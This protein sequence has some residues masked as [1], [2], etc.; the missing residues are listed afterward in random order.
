MNKS[1]GVSTFTI[2]FLLLFHF[3]LIGEN[4]GKT[5]P[6]DERQDLSGEWQ[7]DS[8]EEDGAIEKQH[9]NLLFYSKDKK[10]NTEAISS[11]DARSRKNIGGTNRYNSLSGVL[12][13]LMLIQ[14]GAIPGDEMTLS[15]VRGINSFGIS[16]RFPLVLYDGIETDNRRI[17]PYS[18]ERVTVLKDAAAT[19]MYGIRGAGGVI[20]IESR[21]G[22][23]GPVTV[24]VNS[25]GSVLQPMRVPSFL[26]S[27]DYARLYNEARMNEGNDPRYSDE[28]IEGY[29][30]GTDP[31]NYPDINWVNNYLQDYTYQTRNNISFSG[32]DE[33]INYFLSGGYVYNTGIFKT[34]EDENPY[35]TNTNFSATNMQARLNY[36]G[37]T[38]LDLHVD[39]KGRFDSRR[40]PGRY[41]DF[42]SRVFGQLYN[43]P[44]LAYPV[45]N[46]DGS[47]GG[48]ADF[49]DN[50]F[51]LL[52]NSGY[53]IWERT[54]ISSIV[55]LSYDLGF[56]AQGLR[57][58]S[59]FGYLSFADHITDRSKEF[60][61]YQYLG[62][63]EYDQFGQNESMNNASRYEENRRNLSGEVGLNYQTNLGDDFFSAGL[64]AEY[65]EQSARVEM[66]PRVYQSI[67][68][69]A[70]YRMND[71]YLLDLVFSYSGSEQFP[72]NNRYGFFP[73]ASLGWIL[74]EESFL[75]N[76]SFVNFLKIRTSYG[77]TGNDFDPY[78]SNKPYFGYLENF[79][80]GNGYHFGYDASWMQG[81]Y[82][83][84]VRNPALIWE[85]VAKFNIG[86]DA[87]FL[88]N[89][90][91]LS[92]DYFN[93]ETKDI[94]IVGT[95]Q[96]IMGSEFWNPS[97]IAENKG[98]DANIGWRGE[99]GNFI[100]GLNA[101]F[102]Y[103]EN[104]ITEQDE[105]LLA[106]PWMQTTGNPI[107]AL[108]G[109]TFDRYFTE[110]D[111]INDVPDHSMLGELKPGDL[112]YKDLNGDGLIDQRDISMIANPDLPKMFFGFQLDMQIRNFDFNAL[113]QGAAG[114]ET[115][116][117]NPFL[118]E[119]HNSR[120]NVTEE[121]LDR[122]VAGSGQDASYP[123]LGI[124]K[125]DINRVNSTYWVRELNYLRLK[126][127]ELGYSFSSN[128]LNNY[129]ISKLRLYVSAYN[130]L[131]WDNA[132]SMDP[133]YRSSGYSYPLNRYF[134]AGFNLK[135]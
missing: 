52:N 81:L 51:G 98:I 127:A 2:L 17:D 35:N 134:T 85:T 90:L 12:P 72:P 126:S 39:I 54:M 24:E 86:L 61:V 76:Q 107:N 60:A 114:A 11:I 97:G 1:P 118:F 67:R 99:V 111:N 133:E 13:G 4:A 103:A 25:Q 55:N 129:N 66:L 109:Y 7:V 112:T 36:S 33:N 88:D 132:G 77:L 50:I 75:N 62:D 87:A 80:S 68:G 40:T 16:N 28:D 121:H 21:E 3:Q 9:L 27:Y 91:S 94:L 41:E 20:L 83:E 122:W 102:L 70:G 82:E 78:D 34:E 48:N 19:A 45:F 95:N 106:Y 120:G 65:L 57:L 59:R 42:E 100:Y 123:S 8:L 96:Q 89:R 6:S 29:A 14:R 38:G 73:A 46:P 53:S 79:T 30:S 69:F 23:K 131:T 44:A 26:G 74:S 71:K 105:P 110:N 108:F 15:R 5:V 130:L 93:E 58:S 124:D 32:G 49:R 64:F 92:A 84:G 43:T 119:F 128:W 10:Y 116:F 18:I 37:I 56:I 22:S 47:L 31:Y 115:I 135:F 101:N 104:T 113:L 125:T 117:N 63:D